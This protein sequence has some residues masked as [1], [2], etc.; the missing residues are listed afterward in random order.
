MAG[1]YAPGPVMSEVHARH[2]I[3]PQLFFVGRKATGA[4]VLRLP[5]A[6]RDASFRW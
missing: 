5:A 4:G 3:S 6:R 2:G 1:S